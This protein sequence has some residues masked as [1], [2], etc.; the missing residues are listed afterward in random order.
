MEV[1]AVIFDLDGVIT[2][3]AVYHFKSW[4]DIAKKFGYTLKEEDNEHLKGVSRSES[5]DL[6]LK[7]CGKSLSESQKSQLLIEKN[8]QYLKRISGLSTEDILPGVISFLDHLDSLNIQKAI[9][10][11]SKNAIPILEKL[12]LLERFDIIID[13]NQVTKT[14]PDP[15]VFLKAAAALQ[16]APPYC[17]VV[18]DAPAGI[19][20]AVDA[21]MKCVGIGHHDLLADVVLP[22]LEGFT[23]ETL[24]P[25]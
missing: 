17:L 9:G 14:K 4:S 13:G 12:G 2:D 22:S 25:I 15:E 8:D 18:E 21:G 20:A 3:T 1:K 16:V 10:S 23:I 5:L 7:W 11:S 19:Q 24:Y 6:I